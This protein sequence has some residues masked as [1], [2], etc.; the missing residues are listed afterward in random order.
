[1]QIVEKG[2]R[3]RYVLISKLIKIFDLWTFLN[4]CKDLAYLFLLLVALRTL[5]DN[6]EKHILINEHQNLRNRT[7]SV[8]TQ[9]FLSTRVGSENSRILLTH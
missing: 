4:F 3:L 7:F 2:R 8:F 5:K 1:M 6:R 9:P